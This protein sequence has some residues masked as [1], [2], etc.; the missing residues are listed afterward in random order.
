[1]MIWQVLGPAAPT[2]T[3]RVLTV[4]SYPE[5]VVWGPWF[6]PERGHCHSRIWP[7]QA[8]PLIT[9][10]RGC[11]NPSSIPGPLQPNRYASVWSA[12]LHPVLGPGK[13]RVANQAQEGA[14]EIQGFPRAQ[15]AP[16]RP[17]LRHNDEPTALR[18]Q[19]LVLNTAVSSYCVALNSNWVPPL[20]RML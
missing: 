15:R 12:H 13:C 16:S 3:W 20:P 8:M 14:S 19:H 7:G 5:P 17:R 2:D 4:P 10:F 11:T 6:W 9:A 1:M 18:I